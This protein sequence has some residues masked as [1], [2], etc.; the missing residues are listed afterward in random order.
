VF[1]EIMTNT[2]NISG[3]FS[4][5]RKPDTGYLAE[6]RIRFFRRNRHD[7]GTNPPL[8]RAR[9][10]SRRLGL[11]GNL[12][13]PETNQLINS[14]HELKTPSKKLQN[15]PCRLPALSRLV[16]AIRTGTKRYQKKKKESIPRIAS[17]LI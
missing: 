5:M 14:R 10:K 1:L 8:L 3:D 16:F 17:K 4:A 9:L 6:S 7:A 15:E 13:P 2:G 12:L 11:E